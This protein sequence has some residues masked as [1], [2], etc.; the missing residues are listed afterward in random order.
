MGRPQHGGGLFRLPFRRF[1]AAA[2]A[3]HPNFPA[4]GAQSV[5]PRRR[6]RWGFRQ[7][8]GQISF[9]SSQPL[10]SDREPRP[11]PMCSDLSLFNHPSAQAKKSFARIGALRKYGGLLVHRPSPHPQRVTA[12]CGVTGCQSLNAFNIHFGQLLDKSQNRIELLRQRGEGLRPRTLMRA[13]LAPACRCFHQSTSGYPHLLVLASTAPAPPACK[14]WAVW[15]QASRPKIRPALSTIAR[16]FRRVRP[17]LSTGS[18]TMNIIGFGGGPHP[19]GTDSFPHRDRRKIRL[20]G[21]P[22]LTGNPDAGP[23]DQHAA[24]CRGLPRIFWLR[25][26]HFDHTGRV[27]DKSPRNTGATGMSGMYELDAI[28]SRHWSCRKG[29]PS[30]MGGTFHS[31]I[32]GHGQHACC[33]AFLHR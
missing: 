22:W 23:R 15:A 10:R 6:L 32:A 3:R 21:D 30:N 18:G 14:S 13:S 16:A 29:P 20:C 28:S 8:F 19:R 26:G 9:E 31:G 27:V 12:F 1:I 7:A 4:Y 2:A 11:D 24:R 17:E 33:L 5:Q 25:H